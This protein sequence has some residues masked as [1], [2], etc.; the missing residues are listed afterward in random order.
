[1][2]A[3]STATKTEGKPAQYS[4]CLMLIRLSDTYRNN[5]RG[6][7]PIIDEI[8]RAYMERYPDPKDSTPDNECCE[9]ALTGQYDFYLIFKY[10]SDG[11]VWLAARLH[12]CGVAAEVV[13]M[14]T[15]PLRRFQQHFR[16]KD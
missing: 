8:S 11:P 12:D 2:T 7:V 9:G 13:T 5:L 4:W 10:I 16:Q 14:Q 6:V 15:M 1:M 3:E